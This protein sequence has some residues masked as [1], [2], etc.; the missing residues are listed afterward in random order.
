VALYNGSSKV[1]WRKKKKKKNASSI[2]GKKS[3]SP[4]LIELA[5]EAI[6]KYSLSCL[7]KKIAAIQRWCAYLPF[8]LKKGR[9]KRRGKKEE[10]T[11]GRHDKESTAIC[12]QI[13]LQINRQTN[14]QINFSL[15]RAHRV[16]LSDI[17]IEC[18]RG[19]CTPRSFYS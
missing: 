6:H 2:I 4:G 5:P 13:N 8:S 16:R 14:R 11:T 3:A 17:F 1:G 15:R 19:P 12:W 7:Y 10:F 18:R 9:K